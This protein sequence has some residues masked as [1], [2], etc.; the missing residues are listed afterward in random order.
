MSLEEDIRALRSTLSDNSVKTYASL[1]RHLFITLEI[2][3]PIN[4]SS[5]AAYYKPIVF[6]VNSLTPKK[7]KSI[8]SACLVFVDGTNTPAEQNYRQLVSAAFKQENKDEENQVLTRR[9]QEAYIPWIEILQ[10][11]EE[12]SHTIDWSDGSPNRDA[13]QDYVILCLYTYNP[14]R[15]CMDYCLM[16]NPNKL[17]PINDTINHVNL[18]DG[19]FIFNRYKTSRTYDAQIVD[20][21]PTLLDILKKWLKWNRSSWL[22]YQNNLSPYTPDLMTKRLQK[23]MQKPGFGVNILRHAYVNDVVLPTM[24]YISDLKT[25]A[26]DLGHSFKETV[27]YKKHV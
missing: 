12:L 15:R 5:I 2:D 10:R 21:N 4:A 20:I 11:R 6:W 24:P 8:L 14:P 17:S 22:I 26:N 13:L 7:R 18:E 1:L 9:Q 27:L 23:I 19:V 3:E 25:T 16:A